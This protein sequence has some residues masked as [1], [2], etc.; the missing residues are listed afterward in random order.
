[1]FGQ[2]AHKTQ[3]ITLS[4]PQ[5]GGLSLTVMSHKQTYN[6]KYKPKR[7]PNKTLGFSWDGCVYSACNTAKLS[8]WF[9]SQNR[10]FYW[11][12]QCHLYLGPY[13]ISTNQSFTTH[14]PNTYIYVIH[15]TVLWKNLQAY[16]I[17]GTVQQEK[18]HK[19]QRASRALGIA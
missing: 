17:E 5:K 13:L 11:L 6:R 8:D 1:M 18:A 4:Q 14:A 12:R 2:K 15:L 9:N 16:N 10:V 19:F 7:L 3:Q